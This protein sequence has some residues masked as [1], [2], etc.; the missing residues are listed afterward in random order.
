MEF[1]LKS[2][3]IDSIRNESGIYYGRNRQ[4]NRTCWSKSGD[5]FGTVRGYANFVSGNVEIVLD[6]DGIDVRIVPRGGIPHE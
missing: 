2:V 6:S 4:D 1:R 5:G 3:K